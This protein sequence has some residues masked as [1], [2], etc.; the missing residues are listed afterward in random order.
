MNLRTIAARVIFQVIFRGVSLS[1]SLPPAL[2]ALAPRDQALV[3]TLCYGICRRYYF[4]AAILNL[5]MENK[6]KSKDDDI[7]ALLLVGLY[8]LTDL[9]IPDYAAVGETVAAVSDFQKPWAKSLV[10]AVLRNYQRQA[11]ALQEEAVQIPAALYS[12]PDWLLGKIKKSWPQQWQAILTA[13][14]EHPPFALR[15][16]QQRSTR[17]NYLQLL[18]AQDIAALAI[19]ETSHGIV[20]ADAMRV[21][22]LPGFYAGMVSVQDGAAQL[23]AGLLDLAPA[24]NVL[25]ACAAPGGKTA[26]IAECMPD[27][28]ELIALDRDEKRLLSVSENLT[29][30]HLNATCVHSDAANVQSWWNG[31]LFDR[32]LLDVPCSATGVIRRHPDIKMLRRPE[33][34]D[35]LAA[36]QWRLLT[37]LWPLLQTGGVLLYSTCSIF[38]AENEKLLQRFL[39]ETADAQEFVIEAAWGETRPV[40]RQ[41][42]PGMH[43]MDGFYY[44]R[45]RKW[46]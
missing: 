35:N 42:L 18:A 27:L 33:D 8:Q 45:L 4:L 10:N 21:E 41:I 2:E 20:L 12:H 17:E 40:G 5:L 31:K 22:H 46:S 32:I 6:L 43:G 38:P 7:A 24:L 9:R 39:A 29:R 11:E 26:H 36:E 28:Q 15:V 34:I 1:E 13:N 14:N 16:N 3:Q 44:A 37:S 23:A 25:D 30:L 19:P